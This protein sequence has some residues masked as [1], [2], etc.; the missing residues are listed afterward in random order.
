MSE[1]ESDVMY[2]ANIIENDVNNGIGFR[3]SLF[4]SGCTRKCPFCWNKELWNKCYGKVFTDEVKDEMFAEVSNSYYDGISIL[5]GDPL[6]EYNITEVTELLKEFKETFPNKTVWLWSGAV[7]EDVKDY[8]IF[9]YTDIFIDGLFE[10]DKR[11]L[12]LK[13]RGSSNQRL[14]DVKVSLESN[15]TILATEYY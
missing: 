2:Y 4:I 15:S 6:M 13:W 8:E 7:W 5:G 3:V 10:I 1:K 11:D 12:N 9:R 14:I